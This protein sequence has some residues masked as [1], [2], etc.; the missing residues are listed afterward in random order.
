MA[1]VIKVQDVDPPEAEKEE[2]PAQVKKSLEFD[3]S[4]KP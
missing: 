3:F 1:P 4:D 2:P